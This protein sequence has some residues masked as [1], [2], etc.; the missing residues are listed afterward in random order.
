LWDEIENSVNYVITH[1]NGWEGR[2]Q[3][4]LRRAAAEAGLVPDDLNGQGRIQFLTEGEASLHFCA[5]N[6][7]N[8][9]AILVSYFITV[10]I[11]SH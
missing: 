9:D 10:P 7:L 2:E 8:S 5:Q 6:G 1:P 4:L 3:A 11:F